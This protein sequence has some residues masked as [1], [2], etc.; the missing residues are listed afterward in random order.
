MIEISSL[1]YGRHELILLGTF[2]DHSRNNILLDWARNMP[3]NDDGED[4]GIDAI[5]DAL[6]QAKRAGEYEDFGVYYE[7]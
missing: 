1:L 2:E 6:D 3:E 7:V 5:A 4:D